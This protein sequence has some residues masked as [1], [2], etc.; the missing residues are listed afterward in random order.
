MPW[1]RNPKS[2]VLCTHYH[3]PKWREQMDR[4]LIK[5]AMAILNQRDK[6]T[7]YKWCERKGLCIMVDSGFRKSFV[8]KREFEKVL[9]FKEGVC[10]L[11]K[12]GKVTTA[13]AIQAY[14]SFHSELQN[15]IESKT[16]DI[17]YAPSGQHERKFLSSLTQ[18]T[19]EL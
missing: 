5:E 9:N 1:T 18:S 2:G 8:S 3:K 4:L 13:S 7:F 11:K 6:R 17:N 14:I 15:A 16:K 10:S 19:P 12:Y